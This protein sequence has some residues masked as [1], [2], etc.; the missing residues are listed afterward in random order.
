VVATKTALGLADWCVTEAGFGFDLGGEKFFDI[1]CR[2][3]GLD[4]SVVVL[5]ATVRAL[6]MHGGVGL[7]ALSTPDPD[8]VRR[9][10]PN[11]AKHADNVGLF[12]KPVVVAINRFTDDTDQEIGVVEAWC[13]D[14]RLAMQATDHFARGPDGAVELAKVVEEVA[15]APSGTAQLL[16]E[17]EAPIRDKLHA[18][19]TRIYGAR[20]VVYTTGAERALDRI[21]ALGHAALPVCVAK[22]QSSLSDDPRVHGCPTDFAITVRD[23]TVSAGAGF[24]VALTGD[25]LRMPGLP[26]VPQAEHIDLVDGVIQGLR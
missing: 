12:G 11:L 9:G 14:R 22:T 2:A 7:K 19:A 23:L 15:S 16:Y 4:P 24:V 26:R 25:I 13:R 10:L 6:K 3:S 18:V 1:K 5:I 20:E 17:T 8:A 21:D